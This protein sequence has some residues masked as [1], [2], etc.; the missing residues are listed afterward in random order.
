MHKKSKLLMAIVGAGLIGILSGC[1]SQEQP[2][3]TAPI[4]AQTPETSTLREDLSSGHISLKDNDLTTRPE[5][6][7]I[8]NKSQETSNNKGN[9]LPTPQP[10]ALSGETNELVALV[11]TEE[12]AK[13]IAKLYGIEL[14][15]FAAGVAVYTTD[16]NPH[17][18]IQMG[19][20]KGYP[21]LSINR[22]LELH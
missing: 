1:T 5:L 14:K 15:S 17:D 6:Q 12:E 18:I 4:A 13:E 10:S 19:I 22:R 11:D 7:D 16:Q 9:P 21:A 20:D 3:A 2:I 8:I